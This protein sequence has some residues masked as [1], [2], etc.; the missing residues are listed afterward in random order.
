M[1]KA[2]TFSLLLFISTG[3][4]AQ[5]TGKIDKKT[6]EFSIA[7]DQKGNY[8]LIGYQLPSP[9]TKH[10][11]CFSSDENTV[12]AESGKCVLGAYFDTEKIKFGDKIIFLGNYGKIYVKLSYVSGAGNKMIFYLS[13]TGLTIK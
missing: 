12:R 8:T 11:I 4:I 1:N 13:K 7:A 5:V 6:K 2:L 3:A 10:I 9:A